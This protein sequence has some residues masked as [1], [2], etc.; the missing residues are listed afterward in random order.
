LNVSFH[1]IVNTEAGDGATVPIQEDVFC[2]FSSVDSRGEFFDD[3]RPEG[4]VAQLVAFSTYPYPRKVS[5]GDVG[6]VK[7]PNK[8]LGGF[9]GAGPGVVKEQKK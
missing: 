7:I 4:T 2:R 3:L 1:Q 6:K 8:N 9:V 5:A